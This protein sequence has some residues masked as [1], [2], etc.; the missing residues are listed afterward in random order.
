MKN[1][2]LVDFYNYALYVLHSKKICV[3]QKIDFHLWK[4][5]IVRNIRSYLAK[6]KS[7]QM[8]VVVDDYSSWKNNIFIE[9][10]KNRK[11]TLSKFENYSS[12]RTE[13]LS[14]LNDL[15][16]DGRKIIKVQGCEA[17]D[18]IATMVLRNSTDFFTILSADS[19]YAQLLTCSNVKIWNFRQKKYVEVESDIELNL[20]KKIICGQLKLNIPSVLSTLDSGDFAEMSESQ[21]DEVRTNGIEWFIQNNKDIKVVTDSKNLPSKYCSFR[22][23]DI[24]ERIMANAILFDFR[25][26]PI[27][28]SNMIMS[29][30]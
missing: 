30:V 19:D 29:A 11:K 27:Q 10:K 13:C 21:W 15:A 22:N 8:Y 26:I 28:V 3:D 24:Y 4:K 6:F 12:F 5:S 18:I 7:D 2:L 17:D 20:S 1:V 16:G 14:L 9:Y 23:N 25:Q